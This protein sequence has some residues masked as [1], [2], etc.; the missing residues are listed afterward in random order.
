MKPLIVLEDN[1]EVKEI[2]CE[3][4]EGKD[5]EENAISIS[6]QAIEGHSDPITV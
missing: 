5:E 1:Q 4:M 3:E 6:F 2:I